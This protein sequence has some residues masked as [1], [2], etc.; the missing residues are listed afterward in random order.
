MSD[1]DTALHLAVKTKDIDLIDL[2]LSYMPNPTL[3]N[4]M[5]LTPLDMIE[6]ESKRYRK[7]DPIYQQYY[8]PIIFRL[9]AYQST[10]EANSSQGNQ[11]LILELLD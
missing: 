3:V 11:P 6:I 10:Y 8:A 4:S 1:F 5:N 7:E 9:Q 2:L